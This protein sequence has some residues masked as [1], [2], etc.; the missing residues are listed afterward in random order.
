MTRPNNDKEWAVALG[1]IVVAIA[2]G[3]FIEKAIGTI[4]TV[5][6]VEPLV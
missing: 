2:I 3:I 4:P 6:A 1:I 5:A